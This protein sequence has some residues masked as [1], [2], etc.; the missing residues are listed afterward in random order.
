MDVLGID[1]GG[2]GIK[3]AIINTESG[4]SITERYRLPTPEKAQ[5]KDVAKV[6]AELVAHFN[7]RGVF[8]CGFPAIIR[9]GTAFSAA[10]V[11][12]DWIGT[13][14]AALFTKA[15]GMPAYVLN[16]ADAAGIAEMRF[17]A[18]KGQGGVVMVV[19]LG[20]GIGSAI[21]VDGKLLPNSEFGHMSVRGKDAE[22]RASDAVRQAKN[23]SWKKYA[24]RLEE[25]INQMDLLVSPD[26]IIVGG[27]ISKQAD[28]FLPLLKVRPKMVPAQLLNQA[29]II[30]AAMYAAEQ[31]P[32]A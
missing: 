7:Y 32:A 14:A 24:A 10:N 3:G 16:D 22:H 21:F 31:Q 1:I 6:V 29:G 2:S 18:G 4:A 26:L 27:G 5:P 19:T 15:S 9:K 13:D 23:L 8:G 11:S 17:G 12:A 20:T 30:G 25:V 28:E